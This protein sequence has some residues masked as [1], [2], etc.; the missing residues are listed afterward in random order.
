MWETT[1][2]P[3]QA[4]KRKPQEEKG[5]VHLVP[6]SRELSDMEDRDLRR[7]NPTNV[8]TSEPFLQPLILVFSPPILRLL[9]LPEQCRMT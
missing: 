3:D 6:S 9:C 5:V 1:G 4:E 8:L 7:Q 2:R